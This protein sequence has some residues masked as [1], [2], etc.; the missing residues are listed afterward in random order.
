MRVR[1]LGAGGGKKR[2]TVN[3][4]E[5]GRFPNALMEWTAVFLIDANVKHN[6]V[7]WVSIQFNKIFI[8]L[9]KMFV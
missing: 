2:D 5:T 9:F 8:N 6:I 4:V 7:R 1:K 3:E